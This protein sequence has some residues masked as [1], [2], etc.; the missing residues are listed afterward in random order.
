RLLPERHYV[1]VGEAAGLCPGKGFSPR[2]YAHLNPDQAGS[3]LPPLAHYLAHGR[4]GGRAALDRPAGAAAPALP[5]IAAR[6]RPDPAA[7]FAVVLHL[8][9]RDMWEG[10]AA[11]LAR[12]GFAFDLFVTLTA[13]PAQPD[14]AIRARILADFPRAR[15]WTLPNHGRDILPFLHLAQSGLLAPYAAVCKL[16]SKKSPHRDDGDAWREALLDGVIGDPARTGAR[17]G[18]FL[19]DPAAGLWVADGHLARGAEW[20]GPNR[21][22]GEILLTQA[23][24]CKSLP[25]QAGLAAGATGPDLVFAAG[26]IYW[27]RPVA[28]AALAALPVVPGDFEPEMG[29]VDG[30]VAHALERVAGLVAAAAGQQIRQASDL[31]RAIPGRAAADTTDRTASPG[32]QAQED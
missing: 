10:F 13:D 6:D 24:L 2:A 28:L 17:L 27:I 15:I 26:S 9:Y 22:R 7:P 19:D 18:A 32:P 3:G 1:L 23:G 14:A 8:H 20:W 16:H 4:A 30:T 5:A 31:D 11:R 29:Q 21:E 25:T 12:Q